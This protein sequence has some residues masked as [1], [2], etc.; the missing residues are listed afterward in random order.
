ME[1]GLLTV[2]EFLFFFAGVNCRN[3]DA[4]CVLKQF[5][6]GHRSCIGK[7]ISYL[8][9]YKL[10]PSMLRKYEVSVVPFKFFS[11]A[12]NHELKQANTDRA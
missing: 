1:Q 6:A 4:W 2:R 12:V 8:E 5:G 7:N 9:I 11:K 3:A 10:V